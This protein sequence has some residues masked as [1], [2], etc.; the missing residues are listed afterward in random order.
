MT[1]YSVVAV[2]VVECAELIAADVF[3]NADQTRQRL[4]FGDVE[5]YLAQLAGHPRDCGCGRCGL[6][7]RVTAQHVFA[8]AS[9]WQRQVRA[10][11]A[12]GMR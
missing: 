10:T 4:T 2:R 8:I 9:T 1:A 5:R 3:K 12:R 7:S 6:V 11:K